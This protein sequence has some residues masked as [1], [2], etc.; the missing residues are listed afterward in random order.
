[1]FAFLQAAIILAISVAAFIAA[2]FA[3]VHAAKTSDGAFKAAGKQSKA[4]WLVLMI[5]A[6]AI[7]FVSLP[8]PLGNGSGTVG[9]LGIISLGAV[10]FYLVDV[11]PKVS[12]YSGGPSGPRNNNRGTW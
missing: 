10:I 7:A 3:V 8:W 4:L 12:G 6:T 2:I 9:L 1:M 11:K 5:A